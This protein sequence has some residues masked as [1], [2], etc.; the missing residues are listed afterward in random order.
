MTPLRAILLGLALAASAG[1]SDR[2]VL[3][4]E[5]SEF[6]V[7]DLKTGSGVPAKL[8]DEITAEYTLA[9]PDGTIL[10]DITGYKSHT[11]TLGDETVIAGVEEAILGMRPGGVR[12]VVL[13]PDMHYGEEGY[14]DGVV[15]PNTTLTMRVM[16]VAVR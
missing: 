9:L 15:P 13:P 5:H 14:A 12:N 10:V 11:W 6:V 7:T 3:L 4:S 2:K 1:C 16:L 8:G